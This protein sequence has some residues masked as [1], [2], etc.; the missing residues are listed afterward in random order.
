VL[1]AIIAQSLHSQP[2][3]QRNAVVAWLRAHSTNLALTEPQAPSA[4]AAI[5]SM[6]T[7]ARVVAMGEATH[8]THEFLRLRN[9]MFESLVSRGAIAIAL[10]TGFQDALAVDAYLQTP[11]NDSPPDSIVRAMVA[12]SDDGHGNGRTENRELLGW[13]HDYNSAHP[14]RRVRFYGFDL[15]GRTASGGFLNAAKTITATLS[16]VQRVDPAEARRLADRL[17]SRLNGFQSRSYA[18][19]DNAY[20]QLSAADRAVIS[21]VIVDLSMDFRRHEAAWRRAT[22]ADEYWTAAQL[23]SAALELDGFFKA[24]FGRGG[25]PPNATAYRDSAMGANA[26]AIAEHVAP[27]RLFIFAHDVHVEAGGVQVNNGPGKSMG[28]WL[29]AR[30]GRGLFVFGTV[31]GSRLVDNV[32]ATTVVGDSSSLPSVCAETGHPAFVVDLRALPAAGPVRDW[33]S[34][35]RRVNPVAFSQTA[36]YVIDVPRW[37]DAIIFVRDVHIANE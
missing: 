4:L 6:A 34:E 24:N 37:Y 10:E 21:Q 31:D 16:Y 20:D 13:I 28:S 19:K 30:L 15:S 23:S 36:S 18:V 8:G 35:P 25:M 14:S 29:R 1:A 26:A 32:S 17:G 11:G 5:D 33:F 27:G 2:A 22:S 7:S 9:A 3:G 12:Y